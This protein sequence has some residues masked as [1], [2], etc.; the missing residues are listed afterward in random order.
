[1]KTISQEQFIEFMS[2]ALPELVSSVMCE[3]TGAVAKGDISM[4]QFWALHYID[5]LGELT[6]NQLASELNRS[7]SSTSALL[8]RLEKSGMIKRERGTQDQRV[9][10]ISLTAKGKK[11][12]DRLVANRK[13]GIRKTYSTLTPTERTQHMQMIQKI[14]KH[15]RNA[16][17]VAALLLPTLSMAQ[18]TNTYSLDESIRIGLKRSISVANAARER[19]IAGAVRKRAIS[20]AMPKLTGTANYTSFDSDNISGSESKGVGAA[21]SWE[22]FSGGRT[23]SAIRASKSYRELT[24]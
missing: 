16:A 9:V 5:Q 19:E 10:H 11:L 3:D 23:L 7:K 21:A 8:Q 13:Q 22:I 15:A 2:E 18:T 20:Q 14:M 1:M 24:A 6:V 17:L 4:P 12:V